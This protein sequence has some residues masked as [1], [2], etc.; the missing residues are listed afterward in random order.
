MFVCDAIRLKGDPSSGLKT[1]EFGHVEVALRQVGSEPCLLGQGTGSERRWV[2][3][4][5]LVVEGTFLEHHFSTTA[6]EFSV[7]GVFL[8]VV[9]G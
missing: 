8:C 1:V 3:D 2:F 4:A 9:G 5:C 7:V 6:L